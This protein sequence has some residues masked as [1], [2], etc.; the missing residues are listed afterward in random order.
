MSFAFLNAVNPGEII[1]VLLLAVLFFGG[2]HIPEIARALGRSVSEFKKGQQEGTTGKYEDEE[3][4]DQPPTP[5]APPK[6]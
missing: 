3:K 5:P 2:K 6:A 4:K 1:L